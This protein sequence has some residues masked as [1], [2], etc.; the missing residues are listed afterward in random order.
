MGMS[1][2]RVNLD[3]LW[4]VGSARRYDQDSLIHVFWQA[5]RGKLEGAMVHMYTTIR[6]LVQLGLKIR[7]FTQMRS[8]KYQQRP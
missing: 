7:P 5:S 8:G 6:M 1:A 2:A 3:P 4:T